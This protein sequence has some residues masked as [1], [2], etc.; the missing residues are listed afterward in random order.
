VFYYAPWVGLEGCEYLSGLITNMYEVLGRI[1]HS[2]IW[3][4][5]S[6]GW[7]G[8]A[9]SGGCR[10]YCIEVDVLGYKLVCY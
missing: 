10:A 6:K 9:I 2:C 4:R 8:F 3:I 5:F 7:V 1:R